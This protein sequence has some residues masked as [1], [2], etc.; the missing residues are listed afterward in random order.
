MS[1]NP[2]TT[3]WEV[4]ENN[5]LTKEQRDFAAGKFSEIP[6]LVF[7]VCGDEW[8]PFGEINEENKS[9][10]KICAEALNAKR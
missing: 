5:T 10:A 1:D 2:Q 8:I 9:Q 7:I 6:S 3:K 4:F